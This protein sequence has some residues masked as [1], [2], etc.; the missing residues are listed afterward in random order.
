MSAV[1]RPPSPPDVILEVPVGLEFLVVSRLVASGVGSVPGFTL[2]EIDEI[3]TAVDEGCA[4]LGSERAPDDHLVLAFHLLDDEMVVEISG[5]E[6]PSVV[7]DEL[8]VS[9]LEAMVDDHE[10]DVNSN[11]PALRFR[12][13]RR[14]G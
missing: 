8:V 12:K 1:P 9:I 7:P 10:I 11:R 6:G 13:R 2:E 5:P 4:L 14:S 3:K